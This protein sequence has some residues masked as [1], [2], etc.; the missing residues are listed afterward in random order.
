MGNPRY[1]ICLLNKRNLHCTTLARESN[2]IILLQIAT[3]FSIKM[4]ALKLQ[5]QK[6]IY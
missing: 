1:G 5:L 4:L 6:I 3:L 2:P